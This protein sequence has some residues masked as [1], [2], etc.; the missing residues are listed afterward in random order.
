MIQI[1][2]LGYFYFKN[3]YFHIIYYYYWQKSENIFEE[4]N[5][6]TNIIDRIMVF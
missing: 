3:L 6:K 2:N 1:K 4:G 5:R